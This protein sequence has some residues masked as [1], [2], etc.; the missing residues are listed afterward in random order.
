MVVSA[1]PAEALRREWKEHDLEGHVA[2][3]AG[4][5]LGSKKEHLAL[6]TGGRYEP[7]RVLMVGDAPGDRDAATANGVLFYPIDPGFEDE[8]WRRFHEEALP[9]FFAGTYTR[10]HDHMVSP[11]ITP[12]L[13][14]GR[15]TIDFH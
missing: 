1:T 3:I 10:R 9:R 2:L 12:E 11:G 6:T 4:Q 7:D 8:S 5:E 13:R 14:P 15:V